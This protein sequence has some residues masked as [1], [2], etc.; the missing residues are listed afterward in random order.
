MHCRCPLMSKSHQKIPSSTSTSA[1]VTRALGSLHCQ[2][3]LHM[4]FGGRKSLTRMSFDAVLCLPAVLGLSKSTR[5]SGAPC[6]GRMWQGMLQTEIQ[7][8]G[9]LQVHGDIKH[10]GFVVAAHFGVVASLS[11]LTHRDR[12]CDSGVVSVCMC[13]DNALVEPACPLH[14]KPN[15]AAY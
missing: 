10:V 1:T 8:G 4:P 7:R 2:S 13:Q 6:K 3:M 14:H 11:S 5:L 9:M 12:F 15:V